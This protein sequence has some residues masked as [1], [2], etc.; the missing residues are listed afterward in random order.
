[1]S[2]RHAVMQEVV[3]F[4]LTFDVPFLWFL[5]PPPDIG[6]KLEGLDGPIARSSGVSRSEPMPRPTRSSDGSP[7][8][9]KPTRKQPTTSPRPHSDSSQA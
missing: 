6:L 7:R 2:A 3:A 1:M 4:A 5:I 8:S 9:L